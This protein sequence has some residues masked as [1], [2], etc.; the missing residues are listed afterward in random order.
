MRVRLASVMPASR[1]TVCSCERRATVRKPSI[2]ANAPAEAMTVTDKGIRQIPLGSASRT[3][4]IGVAA[5]MAPITNGATSR[6]PT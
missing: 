6:R 4:A 5:A 2:R 3:N 1:R